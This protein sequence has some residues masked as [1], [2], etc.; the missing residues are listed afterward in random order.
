MAQE[1]AIF[2]IFGGTGD[3]AARKLFPALCRSAQE[4]LLNERTQV[5]GLGRAYKADDT[6]RSEVRDALIEFGCRADTANSFVRRV[7][8]Q[9]IGASEPSAFR[10]LG[11]RLEKLRAEHSLPRHFAYYL[12]L[13][14]EVMPATVTG[15]GEAG[16]NAFEDGWSRVVLEKP[17]G[18]DLA[19][20]QELNRLVHRYFA[21]KQVF[22]IDHYLGKETV[23]NLLVFRLANGLIE[24][25]WNRD[26]IESVQ[27]TVG[28]TLGVGSRAGY[29]DKSGALRDMVQNHLTQLL[30]LVAMEVP[31]SIEAD[32]IRYEK[33]KVL[34]SMAPL[35]LSKVV[36]GQYT[37][38]VC[39]GEPAVAYL[40]EA[41]V[42]A[43][44]T[45]ETFVAMELHVDSWRWQ[46]VPFYL[47]TGK[48]M[49][50]KTT[51]IAVRFRRAPVSFFKNLGCSPSSA[52][53]LVITLQPDEGFALYFDIKTPGDPFRVETIPL[54]FDYQER[55]PGI[56]DA[57]QTL[58]L[59]VL[60]GDQ[61]LFVHSEEVEKSWQLF[62]PLIAAPTP[63]RTYAA[64]TWGPPEAEG[65][66]VPEM[67]WLESVR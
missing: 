39:D 41:G 26:R 27:I 31:S 13:P 51:Q 32:A 21:E 16:L 64:G 22:R 5:L 48:R 55:F 63:I 49:P 34:R 2:T 50:Q 9:P 6:F 66:A 17:F 57:Y 54:R 19:S 62:T 14:P 3:L 36:R 28:E 59:D 45:T 12:S 20:A 65:L 53:L 38:G 25:A 18:R 42:P 61:T 43:S 46:G 40:D 47:R 7:H 24:S 1:P 23:Q 44:S 15:L 56:Q 37:A 35:D 67:R 58:L 33:I 10:A 60:E 8:Y 52:D 30:T 11:D 4:G 29:Y